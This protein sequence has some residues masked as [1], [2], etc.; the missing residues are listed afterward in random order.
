MAHRR[1]S[2]GFVV[3]VSACVGIA[4]ACSGRWASAESAA[5]KKIR[6]ELAKPT[7][8]EFNETPL[9][10]VIKYLTDVHGI[11][12]EVNQKKLEEASVT[13]D[14]PITRVLR[15]ASLG[16]ALNLILGDIG[17]TYV[18]ENEVL[19]ITTS[20]QTQR[21]GMPR[22][23][24]VTG[25]VGQADREALLQAVELVLDPP[26][27]EDSKPLPLTSRVRIFRDKL[28]LRGSQPE[29]DRVDE[30]LQRLREA[31]RATAV[32]LAPPP[33]AEDTTARKSRQVMKRSAR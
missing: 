26:V 14:K 8:V 29:H 4:V 12:I 2:R 10:D 3:A 1:G 19:L 13:L 22:V 28:I 21:T 17:I 25:L 7:Q 24:D 11:N 6:E 18:A 30:L 20:E 16:S 15:A 9:R 27:K 5:E 23:H 33:A 32:E 31:P